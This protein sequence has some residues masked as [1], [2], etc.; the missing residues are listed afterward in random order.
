MDSHTHPCCRKC[1]ENVWNRFSDSPPRG[2]REKCVH[3]LPK[4]L[5]GSVHSGFT[6]DCPMLD[7]AHVTTDS[8]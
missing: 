4:D 1:C 6:N 8:E 7:I 2:A 3:R 5:H